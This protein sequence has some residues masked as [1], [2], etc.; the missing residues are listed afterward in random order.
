RGDANAIARMVQVN[1]AYERVLAE[2]T[3]RSAEAG[4]AASGASP[5]RRRRRDRGRGWWLD[6]AMRLSLGAE[7][8]EALA[9]GEQPVHI[10]SCES[11]GSGAVLLITDRRLLWLLDD[12]VLGRVR[13]LPLSS[14]TSVERAAPR[15]WRRSESVRV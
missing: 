1:A 3:G 15:R 13:W 9:E 14:I 10:V 8:I 6:G 11:G 12:M 4:R 7:L 2:R 5:D